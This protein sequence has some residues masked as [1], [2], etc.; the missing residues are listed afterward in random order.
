MSKCTCSTKLENGARVFVQR[1]SASIAAIVKES[2]TCL[3]KLLSKA[4]R[5]PQVQEERPARELPYPTRLRDR[6][7]KRTNQTA[8]TRLDALP[9][10]SRLPRRSLQRHGQRILWQVVRLGSNGARGRDATAPINISGRHGLGRSQLRN[11]VGWRS[12]RPVPT[13]QKVPAQTSQVAT[14]HGSQ[15]KVLKELAQGESPYHKLHTKVAN[16]RKDFVH[17]VSNDISKNHVVVCIEDLQVKNMSQS[18]T[19]KVAQKSG[20][21]RSILDASPFELRR[22]LQYKT[23]WQGGLLVPVPPQN[24]S[25]KCPECGHVSA[26]NRTSQAK[27]V[28]VECEFSANA[29]FVGAVNIREAGLASLACSQASSDV[30]ASCQEPTE[31]IP[32]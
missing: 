28:C 23:Q 27:S 4:S 7:P 16:I 19:K 3:H 18:A 20:L 1:T 13:A 21:N 10:V 9:Q 6:Q 8:K 32:V 2:R 26:E 31:G 29:D 22:Q 12:R 17:K 11:A 15:E 30:R 24:T 14:S 5:L 25:R